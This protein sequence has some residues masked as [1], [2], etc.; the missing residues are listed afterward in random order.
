MHSESSQTPSPFFALSLRLKASQ[1]NF[2]LRLILMQLKT[3][4]KCSQKSLTTS[5]WPNLQ[6]SLFQTIPVYSRESCLRYGYIQGTY[7][8][9]TCRLTRLIID[10]LVLRGSF[11]E[12]FFL[13]CVSMQL[14]L[15]HVVRTSMFAL[16]GAVCQLANAVMDRMTVRMDLMRSVGYIHRI[17]TVF[18][19]F[20]SI[21]QKSMGSKLYENCYHL[22]ILMKFQT[23][24][25][26]FLIKHIKY[27]IFSSVSSR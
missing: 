21:Q 8:P 10:S 14:G 7:C 6:L 4:Q 26:L 23:C 22:L 3:S 1:G 16:E 18:H 17:Y 24:M 15:R 19:L 2:T 9:R 5:H 20:W 27:K 25:A 13:F 12:R 11:D